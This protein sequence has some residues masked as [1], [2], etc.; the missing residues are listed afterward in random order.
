MD[1][2]AGS[3]RR[4]CGMQILLRPAPHDE[5]RKSAGIPLDGWMTASGGVVRGQYRRLQRRAGRRSFGFRDLERVSGTSRPLPST[6]S[7][8]PAARPCLPRAARSCAETGIHTGRSP[9][10][11]FVVRD[12]PPRPGLVGQQRRDHAGAIRPAPGRLPDPCRRQ[13]A[14]RAGS[15]RRRRP[16]LRV[17]A[18]VFTEFAWHSL[19]I[20][21]LLIRPGTA[22]ARE[23]RAG[24][25]HRRPALFKADPAR[26]GC[27]SRNRHRLRLHPQDRADR[28][29]VLCGRDEEVG[30]HLSQ[31]RPAASRA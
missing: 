19:F 16:G 23:L 3:I 7:P 28:R 4:H 10:D 31:L 9:K 1:Q 30:L 27:R 13:G 21:N 26:H 17:K 14:V 29:H 25:H 2:A 5:A 15:L 8:S 6:S 11:K 22:R 18:R 24:A 12:A 20:R